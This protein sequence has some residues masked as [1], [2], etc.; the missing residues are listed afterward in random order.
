MAPEMELT[1]RIRLLNPQQLD[2]LRLFVEFLLS[3]STKPAKNVDEK[4]RYPTKRLL[5]DLERIPVPVDNVILN[6]TA[7]YD[8]RI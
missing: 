8:D 3:K 7:I 5:S 2:E 6:R 4:K 1:E